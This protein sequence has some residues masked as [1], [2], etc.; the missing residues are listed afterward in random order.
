MSSCALDGI[1]AQ[2]LVRTL[3]QTAFMLVESTQAELPAWDAAIEASIDFSGRERG[4]LC[5]VACEQ[6]ACGLARE[7]LGCEGEIR[8]DYCESAVA[9]LLNIFTAWFLES[10]WGL[11][12]E[13]RMGIPQSSRRT[14][15]ETVVSSL[16]SE[17]RAVVSTDAGYVFVCGITIE[18]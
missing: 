15:A 13:H 1:L 11:G 2:Q 9:E 6:G 8:A 12:A 3:E 5:L 14:F 10:W 7:M 4:R 16:D 17:H 18:S